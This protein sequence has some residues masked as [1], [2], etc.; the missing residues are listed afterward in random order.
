MRFMD[1]DLLGNPTGP[2]QFSLFGDGEARLHA[3]AR[4]YTPD[5]VK[6]RAELIAVLETARAASQMPWPQRHADY[7]QTVFPNMANWLPEAEAAQLRF[8]FAREMDRLRAA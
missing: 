5:P 3:P 7:W 4:R 8:E 2:A 1:R 6:I